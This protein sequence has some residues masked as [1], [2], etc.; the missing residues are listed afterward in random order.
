MQDGRSLPPESTGPSLDELDALLADPDRWP[1]LDPDLMRHL[2]FFQCLSYGINPEDETIPRLMALYKVGVERL[3]AE[4]RLQVV[5]HVARAIERVHR[6]R[7]I[8]DGAGCTNGLLPFLLEDPDPGVV[9]VAALEMAVLMPIE[10]G[11]QLTGPRYVQSLVGQV[12]SDDAKAGIL[13]GLLQLGDPRVAPLVEN[14]WTPLS[15]DGRQT[16]ALLIQ[17]FRGLSLLTADFLLAWLEAESN[18]PASATFGVV[19]ATMARAGGHAAEHGLLELTRALPVI[20]APET[21][22]FTVARRWTLDEY[23]PTIAKRLS[24]AARA[25]RPPQL[26]PHVLRYW[27]FGEVAYDLAL[28]AA[29]PAARAATMPDEPL[30]CEPTPLEI[31]PEWDSEEG[32]LL[33]WGVLGASGPTIQTLRVAPLVDEG[34]S[35]LVHTI[36]HPSRNVS[37][38]RAAIPLSESPARLGDVLL[39]AFRANGR[40]GVWLMRGLP[41]YVFASESLAMTLDLLTDLVVNAQIAAARV[42]EEDE[43]LSDPDIHLQFLERLR[44]PSPTPAVVPEEPDGVGLRAPADRAAYRRWLSVAA[45]AGHVASLREQIPEA[46]ERWSAS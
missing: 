12:A 34:V 6:E 17:G 11:D 24:R 45:D 21:Q 16:L 37:Q 19:A 27:G 3:P 18:Q 40:G 14:G 15:E 25:E 28:R 39:A 13:S 1:T 30:L 43:T 8:R 26:M 4:V 2:L 41:A 38:V 10:D 29:A 5:R 42:L 35:L 31:T 33:E 9:G 44:H 22:P 46:W 32:K 36:Y 20:D 23:G 7:D